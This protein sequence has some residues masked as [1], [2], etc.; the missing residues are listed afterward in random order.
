MRKR[1]LS[2]WFNELFAHLKY[3]RP[4]KSAI[5]AY[6]IT[7]A[8]VKKKIMLKYKRNFCKTNIFKSLEILLHEITKTNNDVGPILNFKLLKSITR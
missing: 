5:A 3:I 7:K 6:C 8:T 4:K 2:T 1:T